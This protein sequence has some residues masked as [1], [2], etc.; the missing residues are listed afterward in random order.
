MPLETYLKIRDWKCPSCGS[1]HQFDL[2][3][4]PGVNAGEADHVFFSFICDV[5]Q[6]RFIVRGFAGYWV[7]GAL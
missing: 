7:E 1:G 4:R 2:L 5:C 6:R 3:M